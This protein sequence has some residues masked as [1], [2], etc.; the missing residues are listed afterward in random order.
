M[1]Q[2]TQRGTRTFSALLALS[3]ALTALPGA[4]RA[5]PGE[6]PD[7]QVEIVGLKPG[8]QREVV[9]R[10]TNVGDWWSAATELT[11]ETISPAGG[12]KR[13]IAVPDLNT[14]AEAPLPNQF[15]LTYTLASDCDGH[16]V[17][18]A[19][20]AGSNYMGDKETYLDDNVTQ[21]EV[22]PKRSSAASALSSGGVPPAQGVV[23]DAPQPQGVVG[24]AP[25]GPGLV[26]GGPRLDPAA[27]RGPSPIQ[28]MAPTP[29]LAPP[30]GSPKTDLAIEAISGPREMY[31]VSY[32]IP[33]DFRL[34]N[35]GTD[36]SGGLVVDIRTSGVATIA[37]VQPAGVE[38][39]WAASGF[40]CSVAPGDARKRVMRCAGGS[41]RS[42]EAVAPRV[43]VLFT[44]DGVGI[45][46]A[47]FSG[48]QTSPG[49]GL[50][51]VNPDNNS[52]SLSVQVLRVP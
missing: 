20:S 1:G 6:E 25:R 45:I 42:G 35:D 4:G 34:R 2:T 16:V 30:P 7:L 50:E 12:Q 49:K 43:F 33:Y 48:Y 23:G 8:S 31:L 47:H 22:C 13:T 39:M 17:K 41:L 29:T 21:Q 26:A 40:T 11:V 18:A 5:D 37:S 44:G 19:L 15:E 10:V 27:P 38:P 36:V 51:D 14:V 28:P 24:D 9:V 46:E 32:P 52:A 3:I